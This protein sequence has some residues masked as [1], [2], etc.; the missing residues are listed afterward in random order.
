MVGGERKVS[1][2]QG[3]EF[4]VEG[5]SPQQSLTYSSYRPTFILVSFV[6]LE[7][8]PDKREDTY[9]EESTCR[10]YDNRTQG[11]SLSLRDDNGGRRFESDGV[12]NSGSLQLV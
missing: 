4:E 7:K 2:G 11:L 6:R 8:R 1:K 10:T 9:R 5:K 3:R 12:V